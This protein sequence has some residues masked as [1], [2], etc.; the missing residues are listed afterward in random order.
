MTIE[1]AIETLGN[2][3]AFA[4]FLEVVY[5]LREETIS[6]MTDCSKE[7]IQQKSG[8]IIAMDDVLRMGNWEV[9]RRRFK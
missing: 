9:V 8:F 2:H 4:D 6:D 3:E 7:G 1:K 5:T